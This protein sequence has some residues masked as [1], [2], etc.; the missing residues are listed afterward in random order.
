MRG[1]RTFS[2]RLIELLKGLKTGD[3]IRLSR[4]FHL[5][6]QWWL[7]YGK[8]F[9]GSA[10]MIK[11]NFGHGP[12]FTAD[13]SGT[14]YGIYASGDWMAGSFV[15]DCPQ[16][17]NE[18]HLQGSHEHWK[19]IAL[20][21]LNSE[22]DNINFREMVPIWLAIKRLAP[23]MRN[24]HIVAFSDNS[25]VVY[26]IN[27]GHSVNKSIM[28]LIRS[29]FWECVKFN[30]FLTAKHISGVHNSIADTLSRLDDPFYIHKFMDYVL[31][32]RCTS[33]GTD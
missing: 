11:Y 7:D 4:E 27:K 26:A 20:P 1:G 17:I 3:R 22:D 13:A 32:C 12:W 18:L 9:N 21:L 28:S 23:G 30:V 19:S 29:M 31:C 15:G 24:T 16:W 33:S 6:I 10:I 8:I 5:D 2:R 25:Q 14:G